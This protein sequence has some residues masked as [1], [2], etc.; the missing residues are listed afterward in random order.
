MVPPVDAV[1]S[2]QIPQAGGMLLFKV[3]EPIRG[4]H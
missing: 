1:F 3:G 2:S 4:A